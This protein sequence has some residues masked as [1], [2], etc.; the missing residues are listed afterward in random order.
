MHTSLI[1]HIYAEGEQ[2]PLKENMATLMS[3][4]DL[5]DFVYIKVA[6]DDF[7]TASSIIEPYFNDSPISVCYFPNQPELGEVV[8]FVNALSKIH[9][10]NPDTYIFHAV[11]SG[12]SPRLNDFF[13]KNIKAWREAEWELCTSN[14]DLVEE[15]LEEYS[16]FGS[17]KRNEPMNKGGPYPCPWHYSGTF[18]WVKAED[19][20]LTKW[21]SITPCRHGVEMYLGYL[22][23]RRKAYC[24]YNTQND[25]YHVETNKE[26]WMP[27]LIEPPKESQET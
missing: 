1:Y 13:R 20:W 4:I 27:N 17:F 3:K 15:K 9:D 6:Y 24:I 19:L 18:W 26:D 7:D 12:V 2:E 25:M 23:D 16:C 5:F 8:G 11:T 14:L 21:R 10:T 22:I